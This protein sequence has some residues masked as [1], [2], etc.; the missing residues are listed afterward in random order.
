[1]RNE[2][3]IYPSAIEQIQSTELQE[4]IGF[5]LDSKNNPPYYGSYI[6]E[7]KIFD[8]IED[9]KDRGFYKN[10]PPSF[11]K[12][13]RETMNQIFQNSESHS[14]SIQKINDTVKEPCD[15]TDLTLF[16]GEIA[17]D[18]LKPEELW[19]HQRFNFPSPS[20][21]VTTVGAYILQQSHS[22]FSEYRQGYQWTSKRFDGAKIKHQITGSEHC[23]LRIYQTDITEY[24]TIDPF[25]NEIQIRPIPDQD[26]NYVSAYHSTEASLLVSILKY[27]DQE[28]IKTQFQENNAENLIQWGKS[29]GQEGGT[30]SE[31]F[32][33]CDR[34]PQFLFNICN[35]NYPI[36]ILDEYNK[37]KEQ[38][39]HGITTEMNN[40]YVLYI[41][42]NG[43]LVFSYQNQD[44]SKNPQKKINTRFR[45]DDMEDLIKGLIFQSAK[46]LGRTSAK[47]L[48]DILEYR[49]SPQFSKYQEI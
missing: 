11:Q 25:D 21:F 46:G 33:G 44:N 6:S 45:P 22:F 2:Y 19:D 31:H 23:D 1:M 20:G 12:K 3:L 37:T 40:W 4:R 49:Y 38:T 14:W 18:I 36:P 39:L 8:S 15:L 42:N 28:K 29:L 10:I 16:S 26:Q 9:L 48:L 35:Y 41:A 34:D 43:D 5:L 30:C 7:R 32:G 27:I 17:S 47:Q 13:Y 24:P